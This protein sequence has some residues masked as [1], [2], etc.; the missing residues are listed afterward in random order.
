LPL[1]FWVTFEMLPSVDCVT[2]AVLL[3]PICDKSDVLPLPPWLTVALLSAPSWNRVEP[4]RSPP[5]LTSAKLPDESPATPE[6]VCV[7]R[8]VLLL[9]AWSEWA[10]ISRP[11]FG[12]TRVWL[13]VLTLLLPPWVIE[14]VATRGSVPPTG[15]GSL[16]TDWLMVARFASPIWS[17][18][19]SD[20]CPDWVTKLWLSD[21]DWLTPTIPRLSPA[22]LSKPDWTTSLWLR[23]PDWRT[24]R[25]PDDPD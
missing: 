10:S 23:L 21:P 6:F 20:S 5:W 15:F 4:L 2:V 17:T 16:G 24:L 9:P 12:A 22:L 13:I 7:I 14:A 11:L 1:P 19:A 8:L 25:S 3:V 18:K